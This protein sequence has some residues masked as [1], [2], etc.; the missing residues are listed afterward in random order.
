MHLPLAT[1]LSSLPSTDAKYIHLFPRFLRTRNDMDKEYKT[2][3]QIFI[4]WQIIRHDKNWL[5]KIR[6][7]VL[8]MRLETIRR[9]VK[10]GTPVVPYKFWIKAVQGLPSF[11]I[12]RMRH[13]IWVFAVMFSFLV[14]YHL[15]RCF[16]R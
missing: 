13:N 3:F 6:T 4:G 2:L 9:Q 8:A 11:S 7:A 1:I 5:A 15:F 14:L 12:S 16:F 10:V